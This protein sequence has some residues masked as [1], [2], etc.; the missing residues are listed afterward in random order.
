MSLY[1]FAFL[2]FC[3]LLNL[4]NSLKGKMYPKVIHFK[5][6]FVI[7]DFNFEDQS[8]KD[9]RFQRFPLR[10]QRFQIVHQRVQRVFRVLIKRVLYPILW[11]LSTSLGLGTPYLELVPNANLLFVIGLAHWK[12]LLGPG[13]RNWTFPGSGGPNVNSPLV[14]VAP[15]WTALWFGWPQCEQPSGSGGPNVNSPLVWVAP[16]WTALWFWYLHF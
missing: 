12:L 10:C 6:N 1:L 7:L 2:S 5:A 15:M 14:L 9:F 4:I 3:L 13:G 8:L 16:M 11:S